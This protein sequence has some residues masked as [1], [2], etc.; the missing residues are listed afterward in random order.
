MKKIIIFAITF[1]LVFNVTFQTL[2]ASSYE[3]FFSEKQSEEIEQ[4]LKNLEKNLKV[5]KNGL[6]YIDNQ[7]FYAK[8]SFYPIA[9]ERL[10]ITNNMI[11]KGYLKADYNA[12]IEITDKYI[13]H[14]K[15]EYSKKH[16][17]EEVDVF[18]NKNSITIY[19]SG[20]INKIVWSGLFFTLYLDSGNTNAVA[21]SA[22]TAA[23]ILA[24]WFPD[25]II[26]KIVAT[27]LYLSAGILLIANRNG[28]G[29]IIYA[30]L[31]PIINPIL[32]PNP[33][34]IYWIKSQ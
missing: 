15:N 7:S 11:R 8:S 26:C 1:I 34:I 2:N 25:P 33:F 13:E 32:N 14:V 16:K 3:T 10:L 24:V 30:F 5:D 20:G 22:A 6:L 4:Y 23:S 29:V 27:S 31:N 9:E 18:T 17:T 21:A 12:Q 19:S 28:T